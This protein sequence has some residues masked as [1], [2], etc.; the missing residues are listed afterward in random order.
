MASAQDQP[1]AVT[2]R[3]GRFRVARGYDPSVRIP[4]FVLKCVGFIGEVTHRDSSGVSGDLLATGFFVTVPAESPQLVGMISL[5]FVT[6]RHV[7]NDLAG[8]EPFFLVNKIGGGVTHL[9]SF[10]GGKWWLHPTDPT[11]DIAIIP[12]NW[13]PGL[14]IKA[15]DIKQ[16]GVPERLKQLDIGIGDEIFVTGLFSPASGSKRNIPIVRH[17]NIAM[18]PDEQIQTELGFADV[19]LAEVRSIGGLSGSPVFVRP[20]LGLPIPENITGLKMMF[21]YGHGATLLGLMHGHWDIKESDLNKASVMHDSKRGVNMG[22]GIVVP[23]AKIVETLYRPELVLMRKQGEKEAIKLR[24]PSTDSIRSNAD[25][26]KAMFTKD[27]F[28]TALKKASRKVT[29]QKS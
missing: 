5:F 18:M 11:A 9:L 3:H 20:T 4:D 1:G 10:P 26:T 22:I 16:V 29:P 23:A 6:A 17:G 14:D 27:D 19:Y 24:T 2:V 25:K 28:E 15:V 12:V 7:A 8:R 13:Q 21:G